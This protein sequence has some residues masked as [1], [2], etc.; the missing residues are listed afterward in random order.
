MKGVP[1]FTEGNFPK[2][3]SQCTITIDTAALDTVGNAVMAKYLI[4]AK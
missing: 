3:Y 1:A 2:L 4:F